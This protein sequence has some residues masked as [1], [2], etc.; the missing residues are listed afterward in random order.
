MNAIVKSLAVMEDLVPD[1]DP[2]VQTRNGTDVTVHGINLP[3]SFTTV[4]ALVAD[5]T[6]T[7][8]TRIAI[9][10]Y[11][12]TN[13]SGRLTG[14]V[15]LAGTGVAN[16]GE[17]ID[18]P[19]TT[20]ASQFK[21]DI[22]LQGVDSKL[23]GTEGDGIT[24]D[25]TKL[26]LAALAVGSTEQLTL[27]A[28][29]YFI[30]VNTIFA[31]YV[32]FLPGAELKFAPGVIA[33]FL[34]PEHIIASPSQ[35]IFTDVTTSAQ[36]NLG[37]SGVAHAGWWGA[38]STELDRDNNR[39][40]IQF[41]AHAVIAKGG[42]LVLPGGVININ[43][44]VITM[45][46]NRDTFAL[47]GLHS[48]VSPGSYSS[49]KGTVLNCSTLTGSQV[50]LTIT[51]SLSDP[52]FTVSLVAKDFTIIGPSDQSVTSPGTTT[53]GLAVSNC[54][55]STFENIHTNM[56][57]QGIRASSTFSSTFFR[58]S[59][60][61][62]YYGM[63]F[64]GAQNQTK[65]IDPMAEANWIG[66]AVTDA[67]GGFVVDNP[68]LESCK[69]TGLYVNPKDGGVVD[70]FTLR[71]PYFEDNLGTMIEVG[72]DASFGT[73]RWTING[74]IKN[75]RVEG[76]YINSPTSYPIF[77]NISGLILDVDWTW[78]TNFDIDSTVTISAVSSNTT[79]LAQSGGTASATV[80][81]LNTY[82]DID[83][84]IAGL[85]TLTL[86][87]L[88]QAL[89][90]TPYVFVRNDN[91]IYNSLIKGDSAELIAGV[92]AISLNGANSSISLWKST[93]TTTQWRVCAGGLGGLG[94]WTPGAILDGDEVITTV[95]V[96]G[97]AL[98][99]LAIASFSLD[100]EDLV[101]S[102]AV[103]AADTVTISLA[104]N[105]GSTVTLAVAGD[106]RAKVFK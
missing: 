106:V 6:L 69:S 35:K 52:N 25:S 14:E 53:I 83:N 80:K 71:T 65:V 9:N 63:Y 84:T 89:V 30:D 105:T 85:H 50:G 8:G 16:G 54:I 56:F 38:S 76:T 18:F 22:P 59:S 73:G 12:T 62:C 44:T 32:K 94:S 7:L 90:L 1:A 20:P 23:Y 29:S 77:R 68:N 104:N 55:R 93:T 86:P 82:N 61:G 67:C 92:N 98:G 26:A 88:A 87:P 43:P 15:V 21:Q 37:E 34:S 5:T 46:I 13:N 100:I 19:S 75:F 99:D 17:Y 51:N 33:Y 24:S 91:T 3:Y 102:A 79:V 72:T 48:Q 49:E 81:W 101:I 45:G 74:S 28:G 78:A 96:T 66:I 41:A 11:S 42:K 4:A 40:Y 31:C 27:S 103:T 95:T 97:A 70:S 60:F 2:L 47:V 64:D 58:C 36:V 57:Y 10:N 39:D